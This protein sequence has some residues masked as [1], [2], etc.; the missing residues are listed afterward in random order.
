MTEADK[1]KPT[2]KIF[3]TYTNKVDKKAATLYL[4]KKKNGKLIAIKA[5]KQAN[6]KGKEAKRI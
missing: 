6:N 1:K 4:I 3:N 5:N 2:S